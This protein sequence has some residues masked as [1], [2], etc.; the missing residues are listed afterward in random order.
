MFGRGFPI[1]KVFGIRIEIDL[2]WLFVFVLVSWTLADRVFPEEYPDWSTGTAWTVGVAAA[3]L[4]FGTVLLHELAHA[5]VAKSR[6][7]DVPKIS[8]FIFGGVSHLGRQPSSAREE[9]LI[10][11]AGP[12]TS[13]VIAGVSIGIAAAA[14]GRNEYAEAMFSYLGFVNGILAAFNL[15]PGFPLDGGRVLRSIIWGR[16]RSFRRATEAASG[17]GVAFG[18]GLLFV[19][20]GFILFGYLINGIWF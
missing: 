14:S 7:L 19:G 15:L 9:F 17:V 4:L 6:G 13:I 3:L 1:A 2:S 8:L 18:Y 16:T 5:L 10:A 20:L 12:A 11:A